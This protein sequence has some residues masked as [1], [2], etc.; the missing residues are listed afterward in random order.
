LGSDVVV[1][2]SVA[3]VIVRVRLTDLF[4]AGLPE[5]ATENVS[6]VALA[7]AVGV[8]LIVPVDGVSDRP[9]GRVPLVRAQ[10]YGVVPLVAARLAVY[11]VPTWPFGNEVVVMTSVAGATVNVRLTVLF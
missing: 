10:V 4:W 7:L 8:P 5:S 1:M 9:A 11:A 6:G 3:G 2:I